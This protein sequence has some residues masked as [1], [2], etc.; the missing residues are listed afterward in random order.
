LS[1]VATPVQAE[2]DGFSIAVAVAE[3]VA[4]LVG[5]YIVGY[6]VWQHEV[7][8]WGAVDVVIV[9]VAVTNSDLLALLPWEHASDAHKGMPNATM[10][11]LPSEECRWRIC[12]CSSFRDSTSSARA[13][14]AIW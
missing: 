8:E 14:R 1:L 11:R 10:A 2:Y 5:A 9:V 7:A 3:G 4:T 13:T 6:S 12:R